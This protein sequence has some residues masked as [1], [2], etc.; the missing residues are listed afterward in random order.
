MTH[1]DN[2]L[3]PQSLVMDEAT[4]TPRYAKF[5][6]EPWENGYDI[7]SATLCAGSYCLH[8]GSSGFLV[9]GLWCNARI[10]L[11]P[12][13]LEDVMEIVLNVKAAEITCSENFTRT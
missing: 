5:I 6:T 3:L 2:F 8:G 1:L 7:P 9:S 4:A 11:H 13:W 10:L 12:Q